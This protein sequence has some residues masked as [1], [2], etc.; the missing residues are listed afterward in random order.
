MNQDFEFKQLLRAYRRG[1]INEST[2]EQEIANIEANSASRTGAMPGGFECGGES[3]ESEKVALLHLLDKT[4][5]TEARGA[6]QIT[7]WLQM[8]KLECIGGGLRMINEREAY[9]AKVFGERIKELGGKP[10]ATAVPG[11]L[12]FMTEPTLSDAQKML[13]FA[14]LAGTDPRGFFKPFFD[15]IRNIKEDVV[16]RDMLREFVDDELSSI[17]WLQDTAPGLNGFK[18]IEDAAASDQI[19]GASTTFGLMR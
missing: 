7:K 8:C 11:L 6:E 10:K 13:R 19:G 9:H 3:F 15:V 16:T 5:T 14:L 2:F 1:I 12:A 18:S 17:A 4:R